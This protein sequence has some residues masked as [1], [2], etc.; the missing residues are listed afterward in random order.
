MALVGPSI[1][2]VNNKTSG[3]IKINASTVTVSWSGA[4][5]D[6]DDPICL[7]RVSSFASNDGVTF[8]QDYTDQKTVATTATSGSCTI[9]APS[10]G[11]YMKYAVFTESD[12][13]YADNVY[14]NAIVYRVNYSKCTSPTSIKVNG[15][16][17]AIETT[18]AT[19][20]LTCSGAKA[21]N[22]LS[23][24]AYYVQY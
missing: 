13:W 17:S 18:E 11:K 8:S 6:A 3:T 1:V 7:Y 15:L 12:W 24:S 5:Y 20:T 23:I 14:S 9:N 2:K 4:Q 16:T 19:V 21:G 22:D 10:A